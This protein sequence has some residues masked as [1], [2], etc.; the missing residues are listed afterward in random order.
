MIGAAPI[1]TIAVLGGGIVAHAAAII[2][3]RALPDAS[4]TL[5]ETPIGP[6][7]MADRIDVASA[8]L[9]GFHRK[10][11]LAPELFAREASARPS[12]GTRYARG[13][14]QWLVLEGGDEAPRVDGIAL[15]QLWL[16]QERAEG[17]TIAPWHQFTPLAGLIG[18]IA[19]DAPL[20][21]RLGVHFDPAAYRMLL[22]RLARH[23]GVTMLRSKSWSADLDAHG[24]A[25]LRI[26]DGTQVSADLY[27]DCAGALIEHVGG[28][29]ESWSSFLPGTM[30]RSKSAG[31][32]LDTLTIKEHAIAEDD[33]ETGHRPEGWTANVVAFGDAA[34]TASPSA[35]L[36]P[37]MFDEI[38]R[39]IRFL[40]HA[41][42]APHA[43]AEYN[44]QTRIA[45]AHL[46][47]WSVAP[48]FDP[49]APERP[50]PPGL[51]HLVEQFRA[52]GRVPFR[53]GDPIGAD[54][55]IA[56]LI[57]LG[58][59]PER[60]DPTALVPDD[61]RCSQILQHVLARHAAQPGSAAA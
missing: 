17:R 36:L 60:I 52:R 59:R 48:H 11:G 43:R 25:A 37:A 51:A 61:M 6:S 30:L 49:D 42:G 3:R 53:D 50:L 1:R 12:L 54:D 46:L 13:D 2:F 55:W 7:A 35:Q 38:L 34:F 22:A 40:P 56:M 10:I 32:A 21:E 44:R 19:A 27:A 47:D 8:R 26:D 58:L 39:A 16:R 5:I 18:R 29:F 20:D 28:E 15:H 24:V 4:V 33:S 9:H 57:G 41:D 31:D 45:H 23:L 14:R